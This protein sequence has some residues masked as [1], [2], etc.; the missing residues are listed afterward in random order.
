MKK[1]KSLYC[2]LIFSFLSLS[3]QAEIK[4]VRLAPDTLM[5]D[6]ILGEG[7]SDLL[8]VESNPKQ[9]LIAHSYESLFIT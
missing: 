8:T 9:T 6:L 3:V 4:T 7:P 5:V 2:F 1:D